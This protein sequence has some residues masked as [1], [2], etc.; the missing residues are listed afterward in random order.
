MGDHGGSCVKL[1]VCPLLPPHPLEQT[2]HDR[3]QWGLTSNSFLSKSTWALPRHLFPWRRE[4]L[5]YDLPRDQLVVPWFLL[6][7]FW[8]W[9][10]FS[11]C[12]KPLQTATA[13]LGQWLWPHSDTG[14]FP[15]H[16]T[17]AFCLLPWHR[18]QLLPQCSL[19]DLPVLHP[20]SN[21]ARGQ[22]HQKEQATDKSREEPF[23]CQGSHVIQ[24]Q[25]RPRRAL[26]RAPNDQACQ[27]KHIILWCW[28]SSSRF[29]PTGC[30]SLLTKSQGPIKHKQ[31][32]APASVCQCC[33]RSPNNSSEIWAWSIALCSISF[34]V[35]GKM[36]FFFILMWFLHNLGLTILTEVLRSRGRKKT[37]VTD[38]I[39]VRIYPKLES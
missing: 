20:S 13:C 27:Y 4:S 36:I 32:T 3:R 24:Q 31:H 28:A 16:P 22:R 11:C 7:P 21:T 9:L 1:K 2:L 29:L 26:S 34:W 35:K 12:G 37:A 6:P 25:D 17:Y 10:S 8:T 5:L 14:H 23:C 38:Y 19:T 33:P 18:A 15:W 30:S 39:E